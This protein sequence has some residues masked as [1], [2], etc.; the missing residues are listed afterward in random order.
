MR[1]RLLNDIKNAMKNQN[2]ELLS[3]LRMVKGSV[4][5]EELNKKHELSDEE[6]ISIF[7]KQIKTR[8]E[9]IAEF[10]KGE[11]FDLVEK[12]EKEIQILEKYMPK[13]LSEEEVLGLIDKAFEELKPTSMKDMGGLMNYLTPLLKGKADMSF[14][15]SKVR[16]RLS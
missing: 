1:E 3:V 5:L 12:T 11:R 13:Q 9:S 4:Q 2:R 10:Q 15:S 8:K 16:E 14:V 6:M 7:E